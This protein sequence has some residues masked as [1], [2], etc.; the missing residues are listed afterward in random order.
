M[1][2]RAERDIDQRQRVARQNVRLSAAHDRLADFQTS[3]RDDVTLLAVLVSNQR[4]VRGTI[5]IVFDLRDASG[6]AVFVALEVD[7]PVKPLVTAATTSHRDTTIVVASRN[8]LLRL[9]QR[10]LGHCSER[11]LVTRQIRLVSSRRRCWSKFLYAHRANPLDCF[12][13]IN[14][15]LALLQ[16]YV[17]LLPRRLAAFETPA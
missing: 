2:L 12:A 13:V 5:R 1:D 17:R 7:N 10:L 6:Y 9:E 14:R 15:L 4:D 16:S 8:T 11:Q 3:R